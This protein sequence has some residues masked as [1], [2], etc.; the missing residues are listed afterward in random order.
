MHPDQV[1]VALQRLINAL[2]PDSTTSY[3]ILQPLLQHCTDPNQARTLH[4]S[5]LNHEGYFVQVAAAD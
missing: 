4:F 2:G 5:A 3:G 1:L